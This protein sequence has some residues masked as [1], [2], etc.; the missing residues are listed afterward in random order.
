M[1][2]KTSPSGVVAPA[3]ASKS[4]P[5]LALFQEDEVIYSPTDMPPAYVAEEGVSPKDVKS[6]SGTMG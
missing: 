6:P 5:S 3:P 1:V 2:G 4:M